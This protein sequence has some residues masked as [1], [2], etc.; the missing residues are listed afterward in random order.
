M[1][2]YGAP[3]LTSAGWYS[4]AEALGL[5]TTGAPEGMAGDETDEALGVPE[6]PL[7]LGSDVLSQPPKSM[8]ASAEATTTVRVFTRIR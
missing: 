2:T 4:D 3:A 5:G 1:P 6:D 7:E 8:A